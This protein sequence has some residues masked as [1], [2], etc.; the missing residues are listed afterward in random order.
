MS[1][2]DNGAGIDEE[3]FAECINNYVYEHHYDNEKEDIEEKWSNV[4]LHEKATM[5]I[6]EISKAKSL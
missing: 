6:Q 3:T 4:T 5:I 1:K 2:Y